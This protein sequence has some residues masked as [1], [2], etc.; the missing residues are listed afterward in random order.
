MLINNK[1]KIHF[2]GIGGIGISA[3]AEIVLDLGFKVSG[4]DISSSANI[5]KL[6]KRG[7]TVFIGHD[8]QNVGDVDLLVHSSAVDKNNPELIKA[9]Q[10]GI[11]VLKRS[12]ILADIML[13]K[14]GLAIAGTHGKTTTT[15]MTSTILVESGLDPSYIIGGIVAN[16]KS[17]AKVGRG[18]FLVVEADES[19]GTFLEISPY[20]SVI[21]N[22]DNDHLDFYGSIQN[23]EEAFYKFANKVPFYGLVIMNGDDQKLYEFKSKMKKP[24]IYYGINQERSRDYK[25]YATDITQG[26]DGIKYKLIFENTKEYQVQL[27]VHGK[28]NVQNSLAAIALCWSLGVSISDACKH[29]KMFLGVGRRLEKLYQSKNVIIY[30]DYAHHPTEINASLEAIRNIDSKIHIQLFFEPHRFTRTRDCWNQYLHCFN[31]ANELILLP[32]YPA[33][34]APIPGITSDGLMS[35]VNRL[36]PTFAKI[37]E[38]FEN[39]LLDTIKSTTPKITIVMGAGSIGKRAKEIIKKYGHE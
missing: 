7:A 1:R 17:H 24:H 23:I 4:S 11:P 5:E 30:D 27:N 33:S 22:I 6:K 28:H 16:L 8:P 29:I 13:L 39:D 9:K 38:N 12:E 10:L 14:K 19:D 20:A 15:S 3:I 34:E 31:A 37:T 25:F 36:H 18:E 21:T 2:V 35:D 32:I 26:I